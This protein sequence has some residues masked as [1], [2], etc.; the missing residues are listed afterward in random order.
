MPLASAG[1]GFDV[2]SRLDSIYL[3]YLFPSAAV[4]LGPCYATT[5]YGVI[6]EY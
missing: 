5:N 4:V 2:Y 6:N 1:Y 3:F